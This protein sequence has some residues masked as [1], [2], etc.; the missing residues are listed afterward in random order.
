MDSSSHHS[1]F[2]NFTLLTFLTLKDTL[3]LTKS[4]P[5]L[6]FFHTPNST[7]PSLCNNSN[8]SL[9]LH[10]IPEWSCF[11]FYL[12]KTLQFFVVSLK[13]NDLFPTVLCYFRNLSELNP[14]FYLH[15]CDYYMSLIYSFNGYKFRIYIIQPFN[16]TL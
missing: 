14:I 11:H 3:L 2:Q 16:F 6:M 9:P 1:S 12:N 10:T 5:L 4:H 15:F 7:L 13:Q 8:P